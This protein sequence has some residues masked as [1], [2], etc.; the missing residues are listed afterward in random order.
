[1]TT[2]EKEIK[3]LQ[4]WYFKK[5]GLQLDGKSA[6]EIISLAYQF[7]GRIFSVAYDLIMDGWTN[8]CGIT[9]ELEGR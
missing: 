2:R 1:M 6:N 3:A 8:E 4:E 9:V 7:G 5:T